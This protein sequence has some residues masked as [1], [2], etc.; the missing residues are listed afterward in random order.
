M[1]RDYYQSRQLN[2]GARRRHLRQVNAM[3]RLASRLTKLP[4][5]R[6]TPGLGVLL[7]AFGKFALEYAVVLNDANTKGDLPFLLHSGIERLL[8]EWSILSRACEQRSELSPKSMLASERQESVRYYLEEADKLLLSYCQ[9]WH[10]A[11]PTSSPYIPLQTP[12]A[13]FEKLY[14]ISRALFAPSIPVI[15]IPLSDYDA[16]E[17]WQALAHEMGHHIFWN[18]I[19]L[20]EFAG[21]Q[22][23]MRASVATALL[24]E[25]GVADIS[26]AAEPLRR[27]LG[28]WDDWLEEVF[29]DVCGVLF[30]G[31]A[32]ALS[33]QDLAAASVSKLTDL[34]GEQDEHHPSLYL[35]P[36]IALQVV[37]EVAAASP[38]ADYRQKL[39]DW[40]GLGEV[41][42]QRRALGFEDQLRAQRASQVGSVGSSKRLPAELEAVPET[43]PLNTRWQY[44]AAAA[45]AQQHPAVG[46]TLEELAGDVPVVVRTLLNTGFW[47]GGRKLLDLIDY[48]GRQ[49][50]DADLAELK[51]LS[52]SALPSLDALKNYP[53][54]PPAVPDPQS[55]FQHVLNRVIRGVA[56][57]DLAETEKPRIFWTLLSAMNVEADAGLHIHELGVAPHSH[58]IPILGISMTWKHRHPSWTTIDPAWPPL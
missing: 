46:I 24:D 44:F 1:L 57:A 35:R 41:E 9:R 2:T 16:P 17:N 6:T 12:V 30:A 23:K 40:A 10:Y 28:L 19:E 33:A 26:K 43:F 52:W 29:A 32:F 22:R 18:A 49:A 54:I 56:E 13:Y 5:S 47:P 38:R 37:R 31:P 34:I 14:R 25:L 42:T 58:P 21:V 53:P 39:L 50:S 27:R 36:L 8:Q 20:G 55:D 51:N 4:A 7:D 45:A 15:S 11:A 48:H 3:V